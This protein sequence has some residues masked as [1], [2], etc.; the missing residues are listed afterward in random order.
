MINDFA[1]IYV[2]RHGETETNVKGIL[3]GY[4]SSSLTQ[5][6][7]EQAREL[8]EK[9]KI[10][11]FDAVYSSDLER[12]QKTAEIITQEDDLPIK[13]NNQLRERNFGR[14]EGTER[15]V[16]LENLK[17]AMAKAGNL[18]EDGKWKFRLSDEVESDEE[19]P[20]RFMTALK[21]FTNAFGFWKSR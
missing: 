17:E 4:E 8:S 20:S 1:T 15:K 21:N 3:Q 18:T 6:G 19:L 16:Y 10:V 11:K 13:T 5:R 14:Y 7:I 12:A 9:F 2:V